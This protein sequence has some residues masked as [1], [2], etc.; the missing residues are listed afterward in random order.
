MAPRRA[1]TLRRVTAATTRRRAAAGIRK[2]TRSRQATNRYGQSPICAQ[3]VSRSSENIHATSDSDEPEPSIPEYGHSPASNNR[4]SSSLQPPSIPSSPLPAI[5][6]IPS[7]P[8]STWHPTLTTG[9]IPISLHT[10]RELLRSE[11]QHIIDRVILQLTSRNETRAM[12]HPGSL[13]A[14]PASTHGVQPPQPSSTRIR[15]AQPAGQLAP[16][17]EESQQEATIPQ[18]PRT[19]GTYN[20][21]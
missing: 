17:R 6:S 8:T 10:M 12:P 3:E 11:E 15:I 19:Q 1:S 7:N 16:L 5:S 2:H 4:I 14:P 20:R 21:I 13:P 18:E 9:E